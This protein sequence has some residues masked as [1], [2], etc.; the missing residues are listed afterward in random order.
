MSTSGLAYERNQPASPGD[1]Q[2]D[3]SGPKNLLGKD[4]FGIYTAGLE[5]AGLPDYVKDLFGIY[6]AGFE[7]A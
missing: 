3:Y 6:T 7:T 5:T 4:L 2:M 1:P